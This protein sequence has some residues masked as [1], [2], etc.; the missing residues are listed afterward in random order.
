MD[1]SI[2]NDAV[3]LN[4]L[5]GTQCTHKVYYGFD[6][7]RSLR[8]SP[9]LHERRNCRRCTEPLRSQ[10]DAKGAREVIICSAEVGHQE[11]AARQTYETRFREWEY[12]HHE[13]EVIWY[14]AIA[15]G[16][17][18][19]YHWT[20]AIDVDLG[21]HDLGSQWISAGAVLPE[22]Q[23]GTWHVMDDVNPTS[24]HR[25]PGGWEEYRADRRIAIYIR[26][27]GANATRPMS[28]DER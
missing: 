26:A 16:R 25:V 13:N 5:A 9:F 20:C 14:K 10:F 28:S 2:Y 4:V 15:D 6:V 18:A 24:T 22:K 3:T 27:R 19:G 23:T 11:P 1:A 12:V 21:S 7:M 17:M 8:G